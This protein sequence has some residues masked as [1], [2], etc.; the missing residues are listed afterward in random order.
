M[1]SPFRMVY[2]I[3]GLVC[4]ALGLIGILLPGLPTTP[5]LLLASWCFSRSSRRLESALLRSRLLGPFLLDWQHHRGIRRPVRY[6]AMGFV[7][8]T[9]LAT[10]VLSDFGY[11]FKASIVAL[12]CMG[13]LVIVR[14]PVLPSAAPDESPRVDGAGEN[15]PNDAAVWLGSTNQISQ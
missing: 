4:I 15:N 3:A 12:A 11:A 7:A 8:T 10:C 9:I 6:L 13:L 1:S 5:F 2:L 14:I